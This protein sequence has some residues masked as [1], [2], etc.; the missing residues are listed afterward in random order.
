MSHL[1]FCVYASCFAS[2]NF[3][4]W[5]DSFTQTLCKTFYLI[6]SVLFCIIDVMLSI[7]YL[8]KCAYEIHVYVL[9]LVWCLSMASS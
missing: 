1:R 7:I 3:V 6:Y 9:M 4:I 8:Y 2:I 5:Y